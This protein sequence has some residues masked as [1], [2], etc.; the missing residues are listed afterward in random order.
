MWT[1][2][3]VTNG[4]IRALKL[5]N[6]SPFTHSNA[7]TRFVREGEIL[8]ALDHPCII[9]VYHVG[10]DA[11]MW[12]IVMDWMQGG[13]L[14]LWLQNRLT[15]PQVFEIFRR[16]VSAVGF[17]HA[18]GLVHRDI[19]PS[20]VLFDRS[21]RAVLA[22]FGIAKLRDS[23]THVTTSGLALGTPAY[24]SPEQV[25]ATA[26][27]H[28]TDFYSLGIVLYEMLTGSPPFTSANPLALLNRH[29]TE[30]PA[31]LP[32]RFSDF[33]FLMNA[34]LHKEPRAR[35]PTAEAIMYMV[36]R[37]SR[38]RKLAHDHAG[39]QFQFTL[40]E[41]PYRPPDRPD[42]HGLLRY[43]RRRNDRFY[44]RVWRLYLII[45][46]VMLVAKFLG[47]LETR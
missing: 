17:A 2:A 26:I 19:K 8:C 35:P 47:V 13:D 24:M 9:P 30:D 34:L 27:D 5:L 20:N 40:E 15:L 29:L 31:P 28:R 45:I 43:E 14:A 11:G 7:L 42:N 10:N 3:N 41:I 1:A 33:Q 38:S 23:I 12:Y 4:T 44:S 36:D 6:V 16:V 18:K 37:I 25:R 46:V 21:G 39:R 22:D 32:K